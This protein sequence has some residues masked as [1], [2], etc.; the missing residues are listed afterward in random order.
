M[1]KIAPL[2]SIISSASS[3]LF[4]AFE[5]VLKPFTPHLIPPPH[6]KISPPH[7]ASAV[8][9]SLSTHITEQGMK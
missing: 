4:C 3:H 2:C 6:G 9:W 5:S 7:Q 8:S 1:S